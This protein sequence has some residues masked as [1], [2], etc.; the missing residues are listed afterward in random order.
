MIEKFDAIN[1]RLYFPTAWVSIILCYIEAAILLAYRSAPYTNIIIRKC[2]NDQLE[3][4][5]NR[6]Y[7]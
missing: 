3:S 5:L 1:A 2:V 7:C 6:L 4:S